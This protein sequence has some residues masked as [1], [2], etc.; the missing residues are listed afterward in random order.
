MPLKVS[1]RRNNRRGHV[2]VLSASAVLL[3]LLL[4]IVFISTTPK[5]PTCQAPREYARRSKAAWAA[6]GGSTVLKV[7]TLAAVSSQRTSSIRHT[8]MLGARSELLCL[9]L[10]HSQLVRLH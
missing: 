10:A 1:M 8:T 4:L 9:V 3:G 5:R 2:M 6:V 7:S